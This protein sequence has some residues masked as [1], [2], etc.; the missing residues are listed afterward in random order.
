MKGIPTPTLLS[1]PP[2]TGHPIVL[3]RD[4]TNGG[5]WTEVIVCSDGTMSRPQQIYVTHDRP[6]EEAEMTRV[7]GALEET[8]LL[9]KFGQLIRERSARHVCETGEGVVCLQADFDEGSWD[10]FTVDLEHSSHRRE[11]HMVLVWPTSSPMGAMRQKG[12]LGT[13]SGQPTELIRE[14]L[15]AHA[16]QR[17][18]VEVGRCR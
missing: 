4:I 12:G 7:D 6:D 13:L 2:M 9:L 5:E 16:P 17:S 1:L 11:P 14:S 8:R 15:R 3:D 18:R 10:G